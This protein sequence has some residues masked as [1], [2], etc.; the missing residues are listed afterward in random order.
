[1]DSE[2]QAALDRR[3]QIRD[4]LYDPQRDAFDVIERAA[5]KHARETLEPC[6][7]CSGFG[8]LISDDMIE[9]AA[10]V[11]Q[12]A[13]KPSEALLKRTRAALVAAFTTLE[14]PDGQ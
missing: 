1:M 9:A 4:E 10:M 8:W 3:Q 7:D 6:P 14:A 2:L 12:L 13:G 5:R 11:T